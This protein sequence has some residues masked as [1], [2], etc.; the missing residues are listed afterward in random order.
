[1]RSLRGVQQLWVLALV[2]LTAVAVLGGVT[3]SRLGSLQS[4]QARV[5]QRLLPA[6]ESL[7]RAQQL[8][9]S[10]TS[11]FARVVG[12]P[13]RSGL[14][15]QLATYTTAATNATAAWNDY[16]RFP[17]RFPSEAKLRAR[18]DELSAERTKLLTQILLASPG[19]AQ[20]L[21]RSAVD[22]SSELAR[23]LASLRDAYDSR[24]N[25]STRNAS[26]LT[27]SVTTGV[28][29]TGGASFAVLLVLFG[30]ALQIGRVRERDAR[31]TEAQRATRGHR[32]ELEARFQ[33]ALELARSEEDTYPRVEQALREAVPGAALELLVA[34]SSRAHFHQVVT[35]NAEMS[36]RDCPVSAPAECSAAS[37]GQTQV[38]RSSNALD[39]CFYSRGRPGTGCSAVC[40]PVSIAGKTVG[41]I[42]GTGADHEPFDHEVIATVELI[43]R[44]A[45]ERIGMLRA[46]AR[47]ETQARTDQLSGLLNR[48]S[49]EMQLVDVTNENR[50][51]VVAFG[52]LDHF[53]QLNDV[54]GHDAGDR[55]LRLFARILRD[56]VRPSDIP[57]RYGGEE[58]VV[59]LPDCVVADAVGVIE[60]VRAR[61]GL[62]LEAGGV[63]PFTVSFGLAATEG[64]MTFSQTLELADRALLDA[65]RTGRDRIVAY[66][67]LDPDAETGD[68]SGGE[69][70]EP[71]TT[72]VP[73]TA[74][75]INDSSATPVA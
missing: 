53:K 12:S 4:D 34:D 28:W 17:V 11:D 25:A 3:L 60:R 71:V 36:E 27:D 41:V 75:A 66:G 44:K 68:E 59:V 8:F 29:I 48:R 31:A 52:D 70:A 63:P 64:S 51:F 30:A 18:F 21:T 10:A 5:I 69:P 43:A 57:A 19:A 13:D 65:K 35:T 42:H 54:Y 62:A 20:Q 2:S 56:S 26:V 33:R 72:A 40:V 73:A 67:T 24:I 15:D 16:E 74:V 7:S 32:D 55:A 9:A 46:F 37:R 50:A 38:Y 61:L 1:M 47:S 49:L 14:V 39:A 58:F 45:G 23:E 6:S 22:V